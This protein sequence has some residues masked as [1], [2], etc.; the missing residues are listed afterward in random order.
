MADLRVG[1]I[2]EVQ[3]QRATIRYIGETAFADGE[4]VGVEL[5]HPTGK[6]NGT[7]Q[8]TQYF[9]CREK[10]GMFVRINVPRLMERP[11]KPQQKQPLQKPK[12]SPSPASPTKQLGSRSATPLG[13]SG[14]TTPA[15]S[16]PSSVRP[17]QRPGS[18]G[19]PTKPTPTTTT[20]RGSVSTPG[21]S[22]PPSRPPSTQALSR[23]AGTRTSLKPTPAA[24]P[25]RRPSP[26][27]PP[28]PPSSERVSPGLGARRGSTAT[29]ASAVSVRSTGAEARRGSLAAPAPSSATST[30]P[31]R[32][33]QSAST[34]SGN[35]VPAAE[36]ATAQREVEDLK[37][38][39]SIL[40]RKR[41]EDREK[42]KTLER[43]QEERDKFES[44]IQKIQIKYQPLQQENVE[45]RK[46][47]KEIEAALSQMEQAKMEDDMLLEMAALDREMAEEQAEAYKAELEAVREKAEEYEME[48][49][50]LREENEELSQG[51]DPEQKTSAGWLQLE[52]QNE[53]LKSALLRLREITTQ[54]EE[55]LRDAVK[56]LEEENTDLQKYKD[57]VETAQTR[58]KASESAVED[59]RQQLETALGAEEMLEELTERNMN[60]GEQLD[61]LRATVE[62]LESL[63]EIADELEI[64]HIE[65]EKQMQ[66]ELDYRDT[67][68]RENIQ[69]ILQLEQLNEDAE[70]NIT[71][72]REVV[73]AL[74]SDLEDMKASQ[75]ITETEAE[76]L[77]AR[78]RAMMD[79]NM[80]LQI[81]AAKTQNKTIDLE[82]RR[83]E[84]E[85][86]IEHLKIVQLFLPE[87]YLADKDSIQAL[88]RFRR[89][90]FKAQ[91]LQTF[92][93][94]RI[95]GDM[96]GN[97][98]DT[99]FFAC[100]VCDKLTW[101]SAM[102]DR[103]I[104]CI[105]TCSTDQFTRFQGAVLEL[106][107]VERAL[108]H[109]IEG[110]RR[111]ELNEKKCADELQR[112]MALMSH[113]GEIHLTDSI[114]G[115]AS[116]FNMRTL[117]M[118]S[119]M[120]SSA[121]ALSHLRSIVHHKLPAPQNDESAIIDLED[122]A[123]NFI[124]KAEAAIAACRSA[125]V[126]VTKILR[127][128]DDYR[129]RNFS[130]APTHLPSFFTAEESTEKLAVY[131]RALGHAV[132]NLFHSTDSLTSADFSSPNWDTL[133]TAMTS[134][135]ESHLGYSETD[136]FSALTRDLKSVTNTLV[137]LAALSADIDS[138]LEFDP[139]QPP[140]IQRAYEISHTKTIDHDTESQLHQLQTNMLERATLLAQRDRTI[141]EMSVKI[142][143]LEARTKQTAKQA[144][145]ITELEDTISQ[146]KIKEKDLTDIVESLQEDIIQLETDLAKMKQASAAQPRLPP[147]TVVIGEDGVKRTI[148]AA[149]GEVALTM[150]LELER[151][152]REITALSNSLAFF[153]REAAEL[154]D[155]DTMKPDSWLFQPLLPTPAALARKKTTAKQT[156]L[157]READDVLSELRSAVLESR[158]IALDATRERGWRPVEETVRWRGE[159]V[160]ERWE[161]VAGWREDL[162]RRCREVEGVER[163]GG[164]KS[165]LVREVARVERGRKW[166]RRGWLGGEVR[167]RDGEEWEGVRE[168]LGV[169]EEEEFADRG[170]VSVCVRNR[171]TFFFISLV[172]L[173][174]LGFGGTTY[175]N[176]Y[177]GTILCCS[178]LVTSLR[179]CDHI[180]STYRRS[181]DSPGTTVTL[182]T[183]DSA[184]I[185]AAVV[186]EPASSTTFTAGWGSEVGELGEHGARKASG[187][188]RSLRRPDVMPFVVDID[189]VRCEQWSRRRS[190][191]IRT[192]R[193]VS[194]THIY[195]DDSQVVDSSCT[196]RQVNSAISPDQLWSD[197][198]TDSDAN[199]QTMSAII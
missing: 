158:V 124:K 188:T 81:T 86:A 142:E 185:A 28:P 116:D 128:L 65:S 120:E 53:R 51:M 113:L 155:H 56:S 32:V 148:T 9:V 175:D 114:E 166:A 66:E 72:F 187:A 39:I 99:I 118:Q 4:W 135:T 23:P 62:D 154:R 11:A 195:D 150:G 48:L 83:M 20:K 38:K 171:I 197:D 145:L 125:K 57:E 31:S 2:V 22:T 194:A 163:K 190:F 17:A 30:S 182:G 151:K 80:K 146:A 141:D 7:V 84:A 26:T 95:T 69:R 191:S 129:L 101:V 21:A 29:N 85:E 140:W 180:S 45:L 37:S 58:L 46:N 123:V 13:Q 3:G 143:L 138:T 15:G 100:E 60:M 68:I 134:T 49:E 42:L 18:M 50:I 43:V 136:F 133:L 162:V 176:W 59:L 25:G 167:V 12:P 161:A 172:S 35:T 173:G 54:T 137:D 147:N 179:F 63:K 73:R 6:N 126:V 40:A 19:P 93:K 47:I 193:V 144:A 88:L 178:L 157:A 198:V 170:L 52:K 67:I 64:N 16:R 177:T 107:P 115:A 33:R 168:V 41:E 102:C 10:Y 87:S 111:D 112:T 181:P 139:P 44:I 75:Q 119:Y 77:T 174:S 117:L 79:L 92:V 199:D 96:R 5:D 121:A 97:S 160:R 109:W 1:D 94:E 55:E 196:K 24:V 90:A 82:L 183:P 36:L 74:Q 189:W 127:S 186:E 89:V 98:E 105:N 192:D 106:E 91:L 122:P 132:F 159:R 152:K 34:T 153:R 104:S 14:K 78:S 130:L 156:R 8:D 70:Y 169:D 27:N 165:G 76:E 103:F 184:T 108:N 110:L 61:E 149:G 71:R 131:T 164:M